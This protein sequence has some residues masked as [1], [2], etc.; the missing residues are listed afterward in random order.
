MGPQTHHRLGCT[1]AG[2]SAKNPR[3]APSEALLSRREAGIFERRGS[4]SNRRMTVLQTG[5]EARGSARLAATAD[6]LGAIEEAE[7]AVSEYLQSVASGDRSAHSKG[8]Q[9]CGRMHAVL[10]QTREAMGIWVER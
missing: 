4:D 10:E 2:A 5:P 7:K 3:A 6:H 9:M 1:P 8:L